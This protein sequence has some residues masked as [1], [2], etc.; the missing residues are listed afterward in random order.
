MKREH[1]RREQLGYSRPIRWTSVVLIFCLLQSSAQAYTIYG[2]RALYNLWN[3]RTIG[4]EAFNKKQSVAGS[5]E[6]GNLLYSFDGNNNKAKR[7]TVDDSHSHIPLSIIPDTLKRVGEIPMRSTVT[8]IGAVTYTIPIE[9]ADGRGGLKPQLT[10][11]YNSQS[12]NS[13]LGQ[14]WS[15]NGFSSI[16]RVPHNVYYDGSAKSI[17]LTSA[18]ALAL[19]GMR[20]LTT[21]TTDRFE[22]ESG[23]IRVTAVRVNGDYRSFMV[24]YPNGNVAT[25]GVNVNINGELSFFLSLI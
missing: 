3:E 15:V 9:V 4:N 11:N 1:H 21:G 22:T 23:N 5:R 24:E 20:L 10:L 18:D 25:H 17:S 12:G 2:I 7:T 6:Q 8:P 19:D 16:T 13:Y 14:G